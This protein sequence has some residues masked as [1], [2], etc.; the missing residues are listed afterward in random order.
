MQRGE[1]SSGNL[2]VPKDYVCQQVAQG[3]TPFFV[4][5]IIKYEKLMLQKLLT[6]P[7]TKSGP[8]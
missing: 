5:K 1:L 4:L 8:S 6:Q 7:L 2:A 3:P